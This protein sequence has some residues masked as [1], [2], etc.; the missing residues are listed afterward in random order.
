M[1]NREMLDEE[2]DCKKVRV[3]KKLKKDDR[4]KVRE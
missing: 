1:D 3:E 2:R 4:K